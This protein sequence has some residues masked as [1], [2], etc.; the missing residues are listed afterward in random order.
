PL[1]AVVYNTRS[2]YIFIFC[3]V[4]LVFALH[5]WLTGALLKDYLVAYAALFFLLNYRARLFKRAEG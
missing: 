1:P 5:G 3:G 4:A 2:E